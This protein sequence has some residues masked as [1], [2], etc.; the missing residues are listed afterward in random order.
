MKRNEISL[1]TKIF[2][3]VVNKPKNISFAIIRGMPR[4]Q[5]SFE[6]VFFRVHG[7]SPR[8]KQK[9]CLNL[10]IIRNIHKIL[11]DLWLISS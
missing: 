6:R 3:V 9:M 7:I 11:F 2:F 8:T 5:T 1:K 4:F 10:L